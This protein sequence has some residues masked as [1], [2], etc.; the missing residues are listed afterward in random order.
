MLEGGLQFDGVPRRS[1]PLTDPKGPY[2]DKITYNKGGSV[3]RMIN[4]TMSEP[5]FQ[6]GLRRYLSKHAYGNA[7]HRDLFDAFTGMPGAKC[8]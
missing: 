2:F 1:H 7:V 8:M 5:L 6:M 3:L 4:H